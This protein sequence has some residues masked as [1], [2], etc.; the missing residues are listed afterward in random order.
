MQFSFYDSTQLDIK[1]VQGPRH[2]LFSTHHTRW[3]I[4]LIIFPFIDIVWIFPG[5]SV[6]KGS[7]AS[8]ATSQQCV[9][10]SMS[11]ADADLEVWLENLR[12]E[13]G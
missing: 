2:S 9:A 11:D 8:A 10:A 6:A 4:V 3:S 7:V 5:I 1:T 12:R 13:I